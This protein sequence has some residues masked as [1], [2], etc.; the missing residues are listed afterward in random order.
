M[1]ESPPTP[2]LPTVPP[3]QD[4]SNLG[5]VYITVLGLAN[6]VVTHT[7]N[8]QSLATAVNYLDRIVPIVY[9]AFQAWPASPARVQLDSGMGHDKT[10]QME[11]DENK[12]QSRSRSATRNNENSTNENQEETQLA[13][14]ISKIK[15]R[16]SN[17]EQPTLMKFAEGEPV[18]EGAAGETIIITRNG[19][20][21]AE[22]AAFTPSWFYRGY[23]SLV[24]L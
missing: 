5:F 14:K 17:E 2:P 11:T 21:V 15:P 13:Q 8:W 23:Q 10:N 1:L 7:G 20:K 6:Q 12:T 9:L 22:V 3:A 19:D 24:A 16:K 4:F 18:A